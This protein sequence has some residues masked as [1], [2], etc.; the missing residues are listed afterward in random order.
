MYKMRG[1]NLRS[2]QFAAAMLQ[3]ILLL[4]FPFPAEVRAG[5]PSY[6]Y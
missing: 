6:K 5:A 3:S 4:L 1:R 2:L